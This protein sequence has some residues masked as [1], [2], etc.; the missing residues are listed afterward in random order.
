MRLIY[1]LLVFISTFTFSQASIEYSLSFENIAHHELRV[2][3]KFKEIKS[4]TLE[5]RM[6][7][8]SPG[9]Y[10]GHNFAKNVYEEIAQD[11]SGNKVKLDRLSPSSWLAEV[12]DG[13]VTFSYT[14]YGNYADGTYLGVD[15]RKV[16]MNMPATFVYGVDLDDRKIRLTIPKVEGW[17]VAS[18]LQRINDNVF[19]APNYYYFYDSPT[20][21]GEI[22]WRRWT[23]QGQT[24]EVAMQHEGTTEELDNYVEWIEKVVA[25]HVKQMGDIPKFDFGRYTFLISYN[26][27]VHGDGMEH[28]NS[29]VC[30]STQTLK[31]NAIGLIRTISH[32]FFHAYN[33][34]RI[35]PA[36]LEPFDFDKPNQSEALWFGEGFT[37]Y[38]DRLTLTRTGITTQEEFISGQIYRLNIVING[39][40]R[41]F[42]SAIEMSQQAPFKDAG[43]ANDDTNFE[44]TFVS[45]YVYGS[46]IALGLDLTLRSE[47]NTTLDEYM[48]LV[49]AAYGKT[50]KPYTMTDLGKTLAKVSDEQFARTFFKE[51]IYGNKLPDFKM[52][53]DQFGV[54]L[55]LQSPE[56]V[57]FANPRLD[58]NKKL[59]TPSLR[60]TALYEA[61]METG[62]IL[63]TVD[64]R[65]IDN[66]SDLNRIINSLE[67]GKT[68]KVTFEQMGIKKSGSFVGRQDPRIT[69]S[70]LPESKIKGKEI[71]Q[72]NAWLGFT[73]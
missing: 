63:L 56:S 15:A 47:F 21:V 1:F 65:I 25:Q 3:V 44:N 64:G 60:G 32:E 53:L 68:Y 19:S 73:K 13:Q 2:E 35:R 10:A 66:T 9:R 17:D 67:V 72:R 26:P 49:W 55:S 34:E 5:I 48:R 11:A 14:I 37:D 16:H 23:V 70:Y 36:S 46:I 41:T 40:G 38:Y 6:P 20:M 4:P 8:A 50:E 31:E 58:A 54:K 69:L 12:K 33:I 29:T 62:D 22:D 30:T 57:Y 39:P 59:I 27:W 42:R 18:Q 51:Q 28:R 24:I 61:G 71:K 45:Y 43:T 7:D 52:L